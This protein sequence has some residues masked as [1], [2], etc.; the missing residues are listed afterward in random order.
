METLLELLRC[1]R[2]VEGH[3]STEFGAIRLAPLHAHLLVVLLLDGPSSVPRLRSRL[4]CADSTLSSALRA[5]E[6]RGC[7]RR[8]RDPGR[9]SVAHLALTQPGSLIAGWAWDAISAASWRLGVLA[10][11]DGERVVD[12]LVR[13]T[14]DALRDR[15]GRRP[16][17]RRSHRRR[18]DS[19]LE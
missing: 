1:M 15:R 2:T 5:L 18:E 12:R 9:G 11:E 4:G 16:H 14:D 19:M 7:I 17:R 10:D 6:D 3:L 8:V 13:A